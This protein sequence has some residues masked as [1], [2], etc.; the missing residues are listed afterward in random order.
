MK[1]IGWLVK[2]F[3]IGVFSLYIFNLVGGY[4]EMW[5][6]LNYI[7]AFLTGALGIPGFILVYV[8]SKIVLV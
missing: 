7:T 6:P 3:I 1:I 5:V 8:L 4:F 2:K